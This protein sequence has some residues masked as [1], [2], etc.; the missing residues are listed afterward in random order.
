MLRVALG[1][2]ACAMIF[3][4]AFVWSGTPARVG[5]PLDDAW[6]HLVYAR[7]LLAGHG[8]AY[9]PG[10]LETGLTAPLWTLLLVPLHAVAGTTDQIAWLVKLLGVSLLVTTAWLAARTL[11][12]LQVTR[13]V[14]LASGFAIVADPHGMLGALSG[15][16]VSLTGLL[17]VWLIHSL[18]H[19]DDRH[20]VVSMLL[21]P[22][23][24]PEALFVVLAACVLL[25]RDRSRTRTSR[26]RWLLLAMPWLG[27]IAW[28]A[29]CLHVSGYALPSTFYAKASPSLAAWRHN[30]TTLPTM[31]LSLGWLRFGIGAL[32]CVWGGIVA[33]KPSDAL[34]ESSRVAP[35]LLALSVP[36]YLFAV[37]VSQPLK[38]PLTFYWIRYVLPVAPASLM[39]IALGGD[40]LWSRLRTAGRRRLLLLVPSAM[41]VAWFATVPRVIDHYAW[42]CRNIADINL[43]AAYWLRDHTAR[44]T[45]VATNDA[46]AIAYFSDRPVLDLV[47]LNNHR[48]V[49]GH[50][51]AEVA[52][53][54][55][56]YFAV[57]PSWFPVVDRDPRFRRVFVARAEH[58][59]ISSAKQNELP[60]YRFDP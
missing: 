49:H 44:G 1:L 57:F 59:V 31:L 12:A 8:L 4:A 54:K 9:N 20:A 43:S 42:S 10:Q 13:V 19:H 21:L 47:G 6:I 58:Y 37:V 55:P 7:N 51:Q 56:A 32:L 41:L 18:A 29:Y 27:W 16:E 36:A 35:R 50:L 40:D 53:T 24:R 45:W 60:V 33:W 2:A 39:L 15:M 22:L 17:L 11:I 48:V 52:R 34:Q 46:G 23:A 30:A 38:E 3:A 25:L 14:A 26:D 28:C 5:F